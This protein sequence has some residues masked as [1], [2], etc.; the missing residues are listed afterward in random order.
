[1]NAWLAAVVVMAYYLVALFLLPLALRAWTA[2]PSEV[3][4]KVQHVGFSLSIFLLLELFEHWFAAVAA[5]AALM[6]V[7]YPVLALWEGRSS[8]RRWL[9]DRSVHGGELRRQLLLVQVTFAVLLTVFWGVLGEPWRPLVAV[10]VMAW[11]F[12]DAAAALV[13]RFAGRRRVRHIAVDASKTYE[14]TF[15]MALVATVATAATLHWY[16]GASL[17]L[18][19]AVALLAAPLAA[20]I[21]LVSR[22]GLDSIT[23]PLGTAAVVAPLVLL[24]GALGL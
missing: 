5:S 1:V 13:G 21:E 19:V 10:A 6:A 12:G 2:V 8:Y 7:A 23:V 17:G 4:R 20:G 16:A 22:N 3:I 15:A 9:T 11:G 14:G 24:F 18:S